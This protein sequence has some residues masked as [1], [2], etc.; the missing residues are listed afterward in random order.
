MTEIT[1][2]FNYFVEQFA[3]IKILRYTVD[4]FEKLPLKKKILVY[5]LSEAA[6]SV[7]DIIFDH[8]Y[9]QKLVIRD[10]LE[11]IYKYFDGNRNDIEFEKFIVFLKR[12]WFSNGIHHHYSTDKILPEFSEKYFK[13]LIYSLPNKI[14]NKYFYSKEALIKEILPILFCEHVDNKRVCVDTDA[15]MLKSS[16]NNF[17]EN[18][19]QAEAEEYYKNKFKTAG[20]KPISYGLNSKLEKKDNKIIEKTWM[21]GGMYSEA[22]SKIV[23]FLEKALDYTENTNQKKALEILIDYYKTGNLEIFDEYSI[24]WLKDLDSDIDV[25]NGFIEN[26]GDPLGYKA[27]WESIVNFKNIEASKRTDIISNNAQWFENN[28]PIDDIFRKRVVSGVNAKVINIA[29]LGGE[30]YP[31]AP[32]GINLP[33]ADWLRKEYG[34]KSVSLE[35]IAYAHHKASLSSGFTE[36]FAYSEKEKERS[37][38]Y[39]FIAN[40]LHTDLHECLGHGSGQLL[41][42]ISSD[43]LKNYSSPI[44]EARADLF[45]L[46]FMMDAKIIKLGLMPNVEVAKTQY[47]SYI[48]N[49]L[50]TQIT[51]MQ[52][53]KSIE[54]AHM[55]NRQM[56]AKWCYDKGKEKNIIVKRKEK[57]NTYFVINDYEKLQKLF[58]EL[59]WEIQRVKSE[60][61]FE[62]AKYLIEK[63]G[64]KIDK[65]LHKEVL[66]RFKKLNIAPYTGFLNPEYQLIEDNN[67]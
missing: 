52:L 21:I 42:G 57:N 6:L 50:L 19:S 35:N 20:E 47:D 41:K 43:A 2:H 54:Q 63:Y 13:T 10:I 16:A 66:A 59:L 67:N 39:G 32:L 17:Y 36:E 29:I 37:K 27:T 51:R 23:F 56:I 26:Y 31:A 28:S 65:D 40:N 55:R 33:N 49:G 22:L 38:K 3:D 15:D 61:D 58:G 34:S 30:C 8:N 11:N 60:G 4:G 45:A 64:V 5:Y 7:R 12:I 1:K 46:Y 53:G 18:V 62:T 24:A 44:E 25:T 9:K 48:R 14:I